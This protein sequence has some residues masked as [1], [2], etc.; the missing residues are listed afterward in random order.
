MAFRP[1]P[2]LAAGAAG[3]AVGDFCSP[4]LFPFGAPGLCPAL[5]ASCSCHPIVELTLA[6]MPFWLGTPRRLAAW[7][8]S[9]FR[10]QKLV[11]QAG[12]LLGG[13]GLP[14]CHCQ[15]R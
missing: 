3:F 8:A 2:L 6:A 5:A 14:C 7:A 4:L 12:L 11:D 15:I 1:G 9:F 13:N 10:C